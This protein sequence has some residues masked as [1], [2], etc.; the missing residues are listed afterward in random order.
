MMRHRM[1]AGK[2][3]GALVA[4]AAL[5]L[6]G[7]PPA[8]ADQNWKTSSA[9]WKAMDKCTDAARKAYPDY[10]RESNAKREAARQTCLRTGN[11]PGEAAATPPAPQATEPSR[12]Q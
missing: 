2:L 12:S 10:T 11:L 1:T 3:C 6:A 8:A 5:F 9:V 7:A 4:M